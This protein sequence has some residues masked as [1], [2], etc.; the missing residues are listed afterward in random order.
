[1]ALTVTHPFVSALA[2]GADDTLVR[3]SNW[4]AG[5]TISGT[6]DL[7]QGGTGGANNVT[8][9]DPGVS[10]DSSQGYAAGSTWFN[11]SR[12]ILWQA[13]SVGV[14]VAVWVAGSP[15]HPGYVTTLFY[16]TIRSTQAS[17]SPVLGVQYASPITIQS[18]ITITNL[19]IAVILAGTA[20]VVFL[21]IYANTSGRPG[22][23]I[24]R[25]T[26]SVATTSGGATVS[27]SFSSNPTVGPGIYWIVQ[28][29]TGSI[30]PTVYGATT[31]DY[32]LADHIGSATS[33]GIL[34]N[35]SAKTVGVTNGAALSALQDPFG[36]ATLGSLAPSAFIAV[37]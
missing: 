7:T 8:T 18:R 28:L 27:V 4:N 29:H 33:L 3:P 24:A 23:L 16:P 1:M 15:K 2:D 34:N 37:A 20:S 14:G 12:G 26:S 36:A 10:N 30:A 17:T 21:G 25:G 9:T 5:H 22:A 19:G 35:V 13:V 11:T 6:V 32:L 31:L